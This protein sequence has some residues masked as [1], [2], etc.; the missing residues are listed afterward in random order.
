MVA[1]TCDSLAGIKIAG[2]KLLCRR[3]R[4]RL[5]EEEEEEEEEGMSLDGLAMAFPL[6]KMIR[7]SEP[8]KTPNGGC[9][10]KRALK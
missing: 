8:P 9:Y 7:P 10:L 1:A 6:S 2:I 3:P 5:E 4:R